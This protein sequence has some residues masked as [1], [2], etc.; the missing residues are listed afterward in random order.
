MT[1]F[2]QGPLLRS[3]F[4][5]TFTS[6]SE[7]TGFIKSCVSLCQEG[8]KEHVIS[9]GFFS[10]SLYHPPFSFHFIACGISLPSQ[11]IYY[12]FPLEILY[13]TACVNLPG[14][15]S[16]EICFFMYLQ[17][18][19]QTPWHGLRDGSRVIIELPRRYSFFSSLTLIF[20]P[21]SLKLT[22]QS[23]GGNQEK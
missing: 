9:Q 18:W 11:D 2:T 7:L 3:I 16:E 21:F 14:A 1:P 22:F 12:I 4:F 20:F 17:F 23:Q 15:C 13:A 6:V 8:R 10:F 19:K 5:G